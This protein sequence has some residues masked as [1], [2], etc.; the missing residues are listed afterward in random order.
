MILGGGSILEEGLDFC[1][2][3]FSGVGSLIFGVFVNHCKGH[4]V[5]GGFG[6]G[7]QDSLRY[8]RAREPDRLLLAGWVVSRFFWAGFGQCIRL[9]PSYR[10]RSCKPLP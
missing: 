10:G 5:A 3:Y 6:H 7:G 9:G 4:R 1:L 8:P 2:A